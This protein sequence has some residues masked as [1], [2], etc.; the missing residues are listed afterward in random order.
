MAAADK[1]AT[2]RLSLVN[3]PLM[4]SAGLP[5]RSIRE[6]DQLE[7]LRNFQMA[8]VPVAD[9]TANL[10]FSPPASPRRPEI[11]PLGLKAQAEAAEMTAFRYSK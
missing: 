4:L 3:E 10:L 9:G 8:A 2:P 5:A 7:W 1:P 6:A 11:H